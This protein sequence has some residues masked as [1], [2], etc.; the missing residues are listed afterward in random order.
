M[1]KYSVVS[2]ATITLGSTPWTGDCR[3]SLDTIDH[4]IPSTLDESAGWPAFSREHPF[5]NCPSDRYDLRVRSLGDKRPSVGF[6]ISETSKLT[7]SV[8]CVNSTAIITESL[9]QNYHICYFFEN[10]IRDLLP[11]RSRSEWDLRFARFTGCKVLGADQAYGCAGAQSGW[12]A[13]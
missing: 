12:T 9:D 2:L 5:D 13:Y 10:G 7:K 3:Y 4:S 1:F 6:F 11:Q 8:V